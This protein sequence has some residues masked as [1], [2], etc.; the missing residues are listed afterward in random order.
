MPIAL[1]G[2]NYGKSRV[3]VVKVTRHADRHDLVELIVNVQ[4]EG[5][6]D[7]VHTEGDNRAVLPTDTMKNT[8]Y[9]LARDWDGEQIEEFAL[10]LARHFLGNNPQVSRARIEI[11]Q[12]QWN[13][14]GGRAFERG[15][16]EK[17]TTAVTA[18]QRNIEIQSGVGNMIVLKTSGSAVEGDKKDRYTNLKETSER[19]LATAV[20]A[21]WKYRND[22]VAFGT[23]WRQAREAML[24]TFVE[25]EST[26]VQRTAYTMGEAAL[27]A[28]PEIAEIRLS[29]PNKHCLLI[30][31]AP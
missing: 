21:T 23:C 3:R 14:M 22:S 8:V 12:N 19:I 26:S 31:L 29:L 24:K 5:E 7:A 25:Q 4:F 18:A 11:A 16:E 28:V 15:S 1:A 13:R 2:N 27:Q 6:F 10:V 20:T 9:A 30:D 17:R